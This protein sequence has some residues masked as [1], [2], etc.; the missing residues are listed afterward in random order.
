MGAQTKVSYEAP[1]ALARRRSLSS[2]L[3]ANLAGIE[4]LTDALVAPF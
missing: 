2:E 1:A 3:A 4:A